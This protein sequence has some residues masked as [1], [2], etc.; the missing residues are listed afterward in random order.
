MR[1]V[2]GPLV[3]LV[4]LVFLKLGGADEHRFHVLDLLASSASFAVVGACLPGL[5]RDRVVEEETAATLCKCT[6]RTIRNRLTRA[7]A[8]LSPFM[9]DL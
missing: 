3:H 6:G 9:E 4:H 1:D 5:G 7:A 8:K 2:N